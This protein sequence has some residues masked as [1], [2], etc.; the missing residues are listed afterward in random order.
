MAS[1]HTCTCGGMSGEHDPKNSYC[2]GYGEEEAVGREQRRRVSRARSMAEVAQMSPGLLRRLRRE[3][4]AASR[5][6]LFLRSLPRRGA[7]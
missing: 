6:A 4:E 7:S 5:E 3:S 2:D 1:F